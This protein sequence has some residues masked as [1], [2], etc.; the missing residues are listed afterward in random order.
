MAAMLHVLPDFENF[1]RLAERGN[2]VPVYGQLLG[3]NLTPVTAFAAISEDSGHAFLL[4]SVVGGEKIARYSF[5]G[6]GPRLTFEATRQEVTVADGQ[7][8]T[9]E[10]CVD[11]LTRLADLLASYRAVHLPELPR[12]AG[13]AVGYAGYDVVRYCESLP[14][15]PA[16]DRRLPDLLFGLYD[17]MVVFDHV[18]K[19]ILAI[20][21]AHVGR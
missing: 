17:T 12:F 10:T 16:D 21:H 14:D 5:L 6:A 2:T 1:K 19:T 20:S 18:N 7:R 11:P 15:A 13:G 8:S 4:E 3:D 9:Q